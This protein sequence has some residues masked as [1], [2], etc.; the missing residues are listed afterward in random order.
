M[1][2]DHESCWAPMAWH[3]LNS[4][5]LRRRACCLP[6]FTVVECSL[7]RLVNPRKV[8]ARRLCRFASPLRT[9]CHAAARTA[10]PCPCRRCGQ[11][12]PSFGG[13]PRSSATGSMAG[14]SHPSAPQALL[15]EEH[16]TL[17]PAAA[18]NTPAP[19]WARGLVCMAW[20]PRP[21]AAARCTSCELH[22]PSAG[23]ST[24]CSAGQ[25][26]GHQGGL[27]IVLKPPIDG[28]RSELLRGLLG[29]R[30]AAQWHVM[31]GLEALR[32]L[33]E[34]FASPRHQQKGPVQAGASA[35]PGT[36]ARPM[37]DGRALRPAGPLHSPHNAPTCKND[38]ASV[39]SIDGKPCP[40]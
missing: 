34:A 29:C 26:S 36:P 39:L 10:E 8:P 14:A 21:D 15:L 38:T 22:C 35:W 37:H 7:L 9:G 30:W 18:A 2:L 1:L 4:I 19:P 28:D 32:T 6:I 24:P 25:Q 27:S 3:Y 33:V 17:L 13:A 12:P 11:R 31:R 5:S 23:D 16:P 40:A 20:R